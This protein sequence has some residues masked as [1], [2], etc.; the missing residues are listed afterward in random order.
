MITILPN[1]NGHVVRGYATSA[2]RERAIKQLR[3]RGATHFTRF[4]DVQSRFALSFWSE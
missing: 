2:D 1:R 4:N 3:R